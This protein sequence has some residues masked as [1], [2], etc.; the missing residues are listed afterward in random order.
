MPVPSLQYTSLTELATPASSVSAF[1][2][3]V[4]AKVVPD[5]FWGQ[6][7]IQDHNKACFLKKIHH[8]IHLRQFESM[9][10][11]EVMQGMKVGSTTS[12]SAAS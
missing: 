6:G 8:F 12:R 10:L 5:D 2:Q 4:L 7:S 3:A 9:C 11:H 1:C